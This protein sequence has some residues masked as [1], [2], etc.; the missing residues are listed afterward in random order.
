MNV[1]A[2]RP[3]LGALLAALAPAAAAGSGLPA[4]TQ[5]PVTFDLP[6]DPLTRDA[7]AR[8]QETPVADWRAANERVQA[9]GGW[10]AYL[11]EA[12]GSAGDPHADH[13]HDGRQR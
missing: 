8:W 9:V 3:V 7:Y 1:H 11:E 13:A 5:E 12:H 2:L 10:R 6:H 4:S